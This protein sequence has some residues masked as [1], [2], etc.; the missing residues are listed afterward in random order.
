MSHKNKKFYNEQHDT[1]TVNE[2]P[3]DE[4]STETPVVEVSTVE[5]PLNA[6]EPKKKIAITAETASKTGGYHWMSLNNNGN[7]L[8]GVVVVR[9]HPNIMKALV[10]AGKVRV[11]DFAGLKDV[12]IKNDLVE[13]I[14]ASVLTAMDADGIP[15][16]DMTVVRQT[17]VLKSRLNE[18]ETKLADLEADNLKTLESLPEETRRILIGANKA[19]GQAWIHAHPDTD[20]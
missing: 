17:G 8:I 2:T 12:A 15:A 20:K 1:P 5:Q 19:M 9:V 14:E 18:A 4:V 7:K 13:Y 10:D 6:V 3:V 16:P 11:E